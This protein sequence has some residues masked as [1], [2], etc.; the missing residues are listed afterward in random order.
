MTCNWQQ[1]VVSKSTFSV[2]NKKKN[3]FPTKHEQKIFM[4]TQ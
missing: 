3:T 4:H 2:E 1:A